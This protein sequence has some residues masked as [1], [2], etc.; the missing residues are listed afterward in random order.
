MVGGHKKALNR[1]D[2][3]YDHRMDLVTPIAG[4]FVVE[5]D[6]SAVGQ[7]VL[8]MMYLAEVQL[9]EDSQAL[10]TAHFAREVDLVTAPAKPPSPF[11]PAT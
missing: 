1:P 3:H 5:A 8:R 11:L 10:H 9:A 6:G 4:Q 2:V 7:A